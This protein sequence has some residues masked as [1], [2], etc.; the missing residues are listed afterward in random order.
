MLTYLDLHVLDPISQAPS[1]KLQLEQ[2]GRHFDVAKELIQQIN[3]LMMQEIE[4][5]IEVPHAS[6]SQ[7][8]VFMKEWKK[9]KKREIS[10]QICKMEIH[11]SHAH[12]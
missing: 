12:F 8:H 2:V 7:I 10:S 1:P 4:R 3:W 9:I 6:I 5:W 11:L